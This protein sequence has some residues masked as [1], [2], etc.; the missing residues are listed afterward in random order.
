MKILTT[1]C[2][3]EATSG[4]ELDAFIADLSNRLPLVEGVYSAPV[5]AGVEIALSKLLAY[6]LFK[7]SPVCLYVTGWGIATEHIDLFYGYRRSLGENRALIDSPVHIFEMADQEA[8]ISLLCLVFFFSWDASVFDSTGT[9]LLRT[10]HD[11]WLEIRTSIEALAKNV[12]EE[13]GCYG[14]ALLDR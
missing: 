13:F 5:S 1:E 9:F 8:F 11:G 2:A 7:N 10:S 14:I 6:L 12:T 3:R 4:I